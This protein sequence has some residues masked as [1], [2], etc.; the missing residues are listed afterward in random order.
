TDQISENPPDVG[1]ALAKQHDVRVSPS[2]EDALTLGGGR[3]AVDG[4]LMICEHGR[5]PRSATTS[6]QYPKRR[7]FEEIVKVFEK[8]GR[9]VPVFCDKHLS[10]NWDD[11]KWL[12]DTAKRMK[13]P[14]MAGSSLPTLLRR[15]EANPKR[16]QEI[17]EVDG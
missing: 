11:A 7:F 12:Y 2:I 14:L 4:V 10:D 1:Q 17:E 9:V 5:Y 15:P 13:I 6:I 8:S 3:L 16:G